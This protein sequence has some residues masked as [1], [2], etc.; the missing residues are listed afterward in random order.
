MTNGG[1]A[2]TSG[3]SGFRP[4]PWGTVALI[5]VLVAAVNISSEL[6]ELGRSN[7]SVHW[8]APML[9]ELSSALVIVGIAP[10]IGRAVRRWPPQGDDLVRAGFIH[11]GL[12][13]PFA[14]AHV[15]AVF[16]MREAAYA[17]VGARYGFF[18]DGVLETFL[19]EWRKDVLVYG[20]IAATYWWFQRRAEQPAPARPGDDRIEI[21]DGAGAVFLAPADLLWV[22]AAGNYVEFHTAARTHLARG[23]LA[24]WEARLSE[25]GFARVHR[26]RLVNRGAI[27][28]IKPTPSG[29]VEITLRDGRTLA[30]S[31][32]YRDALNAA[33]AR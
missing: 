21:R 30:G 6:T 18:D 16:V 29:D 27:A 4:G 31:R 12:T 17:A 26:S 25:K 7:S 24:A 13:L 10:L 33:P 19:Y 5:G 15:V 32:R 11:L 3:A 23:T 28:S 8:A 9:W 1:Q 20:A 14:L 22:E 2:G